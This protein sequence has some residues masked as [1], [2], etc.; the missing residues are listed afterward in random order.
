MGIESS[1]GS[2]SCGNDLVEARIAAQIIPAWIEA[3]VAVCW[4][5]RDLRDNF[6]LSLEMLQEF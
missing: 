6:P 4:A 3:E 1:A 2:F 5:R